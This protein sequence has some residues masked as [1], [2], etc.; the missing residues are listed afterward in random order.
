MGFLEKM[1]CELRPT[2]KVPPCVILGDRDHMCKGP[3]VGLKPASSRALLLEL[4]GWED[5]R[6]IKVSLGILE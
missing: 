2:E 3:E 6:Q 1:T 4:S 5:G